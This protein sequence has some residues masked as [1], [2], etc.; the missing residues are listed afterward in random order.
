MSSHIHELWDDLE[1]Q[2]L[3]PELNPD[4][5]SA[6]VN[7]TLDQDLALPSAPAE[8]RK[9]PMKRSI[10]SIVLFAAVLALMAG[11]VLAVAYRSGVLELFFPNGDT[12]QV[13]PYVQTVLAPPKMK[14]TA[15]GWT[16]ASMTG[17]WSMPWSLWRPSTTRPLR[18]S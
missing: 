17:R 8:P 2:L 14:I 12:S 15:C 18:I 5:I 11:S 16:A 9:T 3:Y 6:R 4:D 10:K 13:E 7:A 1:L